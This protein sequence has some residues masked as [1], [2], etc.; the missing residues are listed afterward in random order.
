MG[1]V[2]LARFLFAAAAAG[3]AVLGLAYHDS[4]FRLI[5]ALFLLAGAIGLCIPKTALPGVLAIALHQ[6]VW[7]VIAIP[8]TPL[9]PVNWYGTAE[10]LTSL[11]AALLLAAM[12]DSRLAERGARIAQIVFGATCVFY[13]W[14]HFAYADYT[15]SM[16]PNWLPAHLPFAYLTGV[17]HAAAGLGVIAG[18]LPHLAAFCEAIMMSLF[19]L[20]V[21]LPSFFAD[22]KPSWAAEPKNQWTEVATNWILAF[23]AFVVAFY[24]MRRK[25][26]RQEAGLAMRQ[27]EA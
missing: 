15:A 5:F 11:S 26:E 19:G 22:P 8:A 17:G 27:G 7:A 6:L 3:Q 9:V 23:A 20:L 14:S 16:V 1:I 13:G 10:A 4:T 24:L 25:S 12:L 2:D 21:W 18:V